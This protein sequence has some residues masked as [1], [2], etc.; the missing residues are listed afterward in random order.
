MVPPGTDINSNPNAEEEETNIK[1]RNVRKTLSIITI[2]K[3]IT[4]ANSTLLEYP[5]DQTSR[6]KIL[7]CRNLRQIQSKDSYH[8]RSK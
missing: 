3:T 4:V 2:N 8:N 6:L 1:A 5:Q 7:L